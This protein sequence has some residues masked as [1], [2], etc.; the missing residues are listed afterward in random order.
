MID[1]VIESGNSSKEL[2]P[3]LSAVA[4]QIPRSF[5]VPLP[6]PLTPEVRRILLGLFSNSGAV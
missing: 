4:S 6:V 2:P 3:A 1:L 5:P